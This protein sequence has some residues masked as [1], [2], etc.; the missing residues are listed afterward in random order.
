MWLHGTSLDQS[1]Y[2]MILS[3][4]FSV[5]WSTL[6]R[7]ACKRVMLAHSIRRRCLTII[8]FKKKRTTMNIIKYI[9]MW[10]KLGSSDLY[11]FF[12][13]HSNI[14]WWK[15]K[16]LWLITKTDVFEASEQKTFFFNS[17]YLDITRCFYQILHFFLESWKKNHQEQS[18]ESN[19]MWCS[20]L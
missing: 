16:T 19:L 18:R 8:G 15:W 7:V 17:S 3:T 13:K 6:F 14:I 11:L 10:Q 1:A 20:L 2:L 9:I 5:L 12:T 4:W